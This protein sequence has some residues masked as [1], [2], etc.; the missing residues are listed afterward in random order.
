MNH[1]TTIKGMKKKKVEVVEDMENEGDY[2]ISYF[3]D[4]QN[5]WEGAIKEFPEIE[6]V[7]TIEDMVLT[8]MYKCLDCGSF[9][10]S[11]SECGECGELRLSKIAIPVYYL[12][13]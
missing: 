11:E 8:N 2:L 13:H 9:W 4:K 12:S 1:E 5:A 7:Y 10:I 6:E 3:S